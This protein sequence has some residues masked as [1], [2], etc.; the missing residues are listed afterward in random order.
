MGRY[1]N[2]FG[3]PGKGAHAPRFGGLAAVDLLATLGLS[4]GIAYTARGALGVGAV[5]AVAVVFILLIILA[6]AVHEV[7][8]V[9]TRLNAWV[10]CRPW[11][12]PSVKG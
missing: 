4:C 9:D 6:I 10:F 7:F 2:A 12:Q 8:K 1:S 11:P 5:A 3:V